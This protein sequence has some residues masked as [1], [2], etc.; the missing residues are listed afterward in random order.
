MATKMLK[1]LSTQKAKTSMSFLKELILKGKELL[2]FKKSPKLSNGSSPKIQLK[3]GDRVSDQEFLLRRVFFKDK[4]YIRPDFT[5]SSRAF[6]PRPKD[7][8]KLSVDIESLITSLENAILDVSRFRLYRIPVALPHSIGLT[9][10][11]DPL[12][13]P[14]DIEDNP[15]HS[16][17]SGF[18]EDDESMPRILARSATRVP[19]P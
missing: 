15:A 10:T 9:C 17:I 7:E 13:K 8:G 19:Y 6:S 14:T 1:Y 2:T 12:L 18:T 3:K 11:Y 5:L 16:L 4:R